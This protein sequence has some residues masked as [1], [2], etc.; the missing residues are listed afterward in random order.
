MLY[1]YPARLEERGGTVIATFRDFP[2]AVTE[3]RT[4]GEAAEAAR[5]VLDA[6]IQFRIR[7]GRDLPKASAARRGEIRVGASPGT[8]A[9]ADRPMV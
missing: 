6:A 3:G 5:A 8:A 9:K 4:R 2:E 7:E 1:V